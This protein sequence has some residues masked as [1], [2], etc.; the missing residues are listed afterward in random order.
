MPTVES[1]PVSRPARVAVFGAGIAGLTVA[2]ELARRGFAVSVYE[3]DGAVGGFFRSARLPRDKDM[4]SEYSW[5]GMGPWYHNLFALLKQIPFDDTGSVYDKALSRPIDFGIFPDAGEAAFFDKGLRSIPRMF[6]IS[7]WEFVRAAWLM[8]KTWS[9]HRRTREVYSH[10]NAAEQWKPLLRTRGYMRWR[11]CFGPWIGSDWTNVSLH[12]AGQFF[13]KQLTTRPAHW[14]P[15]D[16]DGPAWSHGAKDGWLL[17]RGPS[18]E[19]WFDRWLS[20]LVKQG[21][22]LHH[23]A[24]L[25]RLLYDGEAITSA[26]LESGETIEADHYVVAVTPFAAAEILARTPELERQEQLKLFKPLTQD[27]PH[28]QVSFRIG[29]DEPIAFPRAR[30]AVVLA[31]TEYNLTLFAEEQVW[32]PQVELGKRI[33]SLWTATSCAATVRGRIHGRPVIECTKEQFLE[34]VLAQ[35][36][37]CGSLD[38]AIRQAN[39]GRGLKD[40]KI[41]RLEVWHEWHFSAAGIRGHQPKWV[42]TTN[43]EP[44]MPDQR[45]P[46]RNLYLA[47]A[48]TRTE[49]DVWSIEAA[50]E[51]GRRAARLIDERVEV[52]P[53]YKPGWLRAL[54]ALDDLCY[55][56]KA[57]HVLD[58]ALIAAAVVAAAVALTVLLA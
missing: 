12:H 26:V 34:E 4:P 45:T 17:L 36:Q 15:P 57:P 16:E 33:E 27:G 20:H 23:D 18:S 21:V 58:V 41:A 10:L 30:T 22:A 9:A 31:D 55:A 14:H 56:V 28:V 39:G 46:V 25:Q 24:P 47:G 5:H 48:H 35:I 29:Y 3:A 52:I 54:G 40:F 19:F 13:C 51:S 38:A 49:A 50:V 37:G 43:T 6:G 7:A 1:S 2:H 53:Q 42:N 44:Y 11:S 32:K 8:L